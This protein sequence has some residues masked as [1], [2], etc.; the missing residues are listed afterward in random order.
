MPRIGDG[1][2]SVLDVS[3][4]EITRLEG[5]WALEMYTVLGK[6]CF[7]IRHEHDDSGHD[8][9]WYMAIAHNSFQMSPGAARVCTRCGEA[10]P[11]TVLGYYILTMHSR[12]DM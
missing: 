11:D 1:T 8:K 2:G 10:A 7:G 9:V 4:S 12:E 5:R 6:P 3:R